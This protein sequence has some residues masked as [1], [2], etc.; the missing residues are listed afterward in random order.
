LSSFGV[1]GSDQSKWEEI[2]P[3]ETFN[4]SVHSVSKNNVHQESHGEKV[5]VSKHEAHDLIIPVDVLD[6]TINIRPAIKAPWTDLVR[7]VKF[8]VT[9]KLVGFPVDD[10]TKG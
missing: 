3:R 4:D 10:Y 8:G 5:G 9:L 6:V 7:H 1:L 2:H